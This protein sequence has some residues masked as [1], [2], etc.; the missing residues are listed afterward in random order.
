MVDD[1]NVRQIR[2]DAVAKEFDPLPA[3]ARATVRARLGRIQARAKD[4]GWGFGD[5]VDELVHALDAR[6]ARARP[7]QVGRR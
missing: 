3:D 1:F 4:I 6:V 2:L 7:G 5:A